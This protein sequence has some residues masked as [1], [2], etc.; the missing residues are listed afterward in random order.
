MA[1]EL[2][3]GHAWSLA[4]DPALPCAGPKLNPVFERWIDGSQWLRFEPT[5]SVDGRH[6]KR[7]AT[8]SSR[9]AVGTLACPDCDAP[10]APPLSPL[11]P[12]DPLGC[13]FCQHSAT[14]R[15]FLSLAAPARPARVAVRLVDRPRLPAVS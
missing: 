5:G 6:E 1:D 3:R 11:S 13:G 10:V 12:A 2:T 9:L 14:V 8:R 4:D 15:D 7:R